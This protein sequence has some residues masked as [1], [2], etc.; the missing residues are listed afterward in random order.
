[1]NIYA[2][3]KFPPFLAYRRRRRRMFITAGGVVLF[4]QSHPFCIIFCLFSSHY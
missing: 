1:M 2:K 4:K 3:Q